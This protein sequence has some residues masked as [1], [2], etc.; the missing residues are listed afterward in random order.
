MEHAGTWAAAMS[1]SVECAFTILTALAALL[2]A[3]EKCGGSVDVD[4]ELIHELVE[5]REELEE[6]TGADR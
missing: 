4:L 6:L 1:T 2:E 5:M 3:V